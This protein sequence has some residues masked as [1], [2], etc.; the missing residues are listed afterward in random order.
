MGTA[1]KKPSRLN[2]ERAAEFVAN[3]LVHSHS[4]M[5]VILKDPS[6][7]PV[8]NMVVEERAGSLFSRYEFDATHATSRCP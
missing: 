1:C 8:L 7:I 6:V 3:V 4:D 2:T 5:N